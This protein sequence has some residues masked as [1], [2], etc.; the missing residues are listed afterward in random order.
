MSLSN[1]SDNHKMGP[2]FGK[3]KSGLITD[4]YRDMWRIYWHYKNNK[5]K[6]SPGSKNLIIYNQAVIRQREDR[7]SS[8]KWPTV[9]D[10]K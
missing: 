7:F 4:P 6:P 10:F 9:W 2:K 3:R 1:N 5:R 8:N